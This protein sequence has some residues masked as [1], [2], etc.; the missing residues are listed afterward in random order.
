MVFCFPITEDFNLKGVAFYD[1]GTGWDHPYTDFCPDQI[2]RNH[3]HY[4]HAVGFGFRM[5][6]PVPL[7]ID[8]GFKL[9]RRKKW[10]ETPYEVHFGM[11]YDW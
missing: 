1:G 3:F 5:M 11:T 9:D 4:R 8:W 6:N 10:D 2:D 7:R